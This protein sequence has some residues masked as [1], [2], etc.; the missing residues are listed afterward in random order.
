MRALNCYLF[1]KQCQLTHFMEALVIRKKNQIF[2]IINGL[3][4][5]GKNNAM[6]SIKWDSSVEGT[7]CGG[8]KSLNENNKSRR[9]LSR[10]LFALFI[11]SWLWSRKRGHNHPLS[12]YW[13]DLRSEGIYSFLI[14]WNLRSKK[15]CPMVSLKLVFFAP[16][17]A[18]HSMG[19]WSYLWR[20]IWSS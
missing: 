13:F 1:W 20:R 18:L 16:E 9:I 10:I 6:E 12:G 14:F 11:H 7:W 8:W 15:G 2:Y 4:E 17:V 19:T 3:S 5:A